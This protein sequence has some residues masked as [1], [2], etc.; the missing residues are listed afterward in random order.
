MKPKKIL[1]NDPDQH[2]DIQFV[3]DI[4]KPNHVASTTR[5]I[6]SQLDSM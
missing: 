5:Q 2:S 6:F 4:G 3:I 1:G